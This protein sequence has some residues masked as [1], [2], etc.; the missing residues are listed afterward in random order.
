MNYALAF[1][2]E[3]SEDLREA[4]RWYENQKVG[5]G[6]DFL[7]CVDQAVN[8]LSVMPEAY[9]VVYRDVRRIL[10]QRFPYAIYFRVVSSRVIVTAVFHSRRAPSAL[11]VRN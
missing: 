7:N 3:V 10:V 11:E 9:A 4:Y 6:E 5:L 8:R 1:R 2:P